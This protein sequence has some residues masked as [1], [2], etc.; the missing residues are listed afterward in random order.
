M[1]GFNA[2]PRDFRSI[3]YARALRSVGLLLQMRDLQAF[4]LSCENSEFRLRCGYQKP[5]CSTPVEM[6]Y[7]LD[8]IEFLESEYQKKS[9]GLDKPVDFYSLG[10][11]LRGIG[12][13]VNKRNG[14]LVKISNNESSMAAGSVK[15]QY[16]T[17]DG[18]LTEEVFTLSS[19]YELCLRLYK[20]RTKSPRSTTLFGS[21]RWREDSSTRS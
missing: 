12:A 9:N 8:E 10:E 17:S 1:L 4:E 6:R 13:Y 7:S 3:G 18:D 16:Q 20:Q 14:R 2:Q 11:V 15:L 19:I 21:S 5:P